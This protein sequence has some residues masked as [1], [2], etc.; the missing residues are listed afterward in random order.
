MTTD[1]I[2]EMQHI[3]KSFPGVKA[4]DHVQLEVRRGEVH[5]ILGENGAGKSTL[6]KI[7]SGAYYKDEGEIRLN[8]KPVDIMNPSHA[9][10]LGI[11][12]IYQEFNLAPHLSVE[13]N[14][15]IGREPRSKI[16]HFINQRKIHAESVKLISEL[17]VDLDVTKKV[18]SLNVSQQ[19][20]TEIAKALSMKSQVVIMDEPTSALSESEV[21]I[22]FRV[23]RHLKK[24]GIGIIYIS[25][26][27]DEVF[28][29]SDRITIMRDGK[30]IGTFHTQEIRPDE[31]VQKMVGRDIHNMYAKK[32]V[33]IGDR[34][35]EVKN[36]SGGMLQDISF[37]LH[38]GEILGVAGLLGAG[39]TELMRCIFGADPA[40]HGDIF[41]DG[42]QCAIRSIEDAIRLGIGF[43]PEDR[44][45][46]G[47][48]LRMTVQSNIASTSIPQISSRGFIQK[49]KENE[50]S[51]KYVNQLQVKVSGLDQLALN[52]SGGN[53]QKLVLAKWLALSPKILLLDDPTRGIDVGAKE[54]IYKL[55]GDL[56][57]NGVGI[58]FVSSELPEV[59]GIADRILVMAEGRIRGELSREEATQEKVMAYATTIRKERSGGGNNGT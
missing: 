52:L 55:I 25:H 45:Q 6:V 59:L 28:E 1:V 32:D 42:K 57:E 17:G 46:Q 18:G 38:Q 48:F 41:V 54:S 35:L 21:E 47:L 5:A 44:K 43:V 39:R 8:K 7:L 2:L 31:A 50:L 27:L 23:I 22:L 3:T 11:A 14:I 16:F 53:Q 51:E 36:L 30:Y 15:F 49:H 33:P 4:L 10:S 26:N 29:I 40:D 13:A 12:M 24:E 37:T 34:I 19:Q 58:I 9:Q 56:A 20:I